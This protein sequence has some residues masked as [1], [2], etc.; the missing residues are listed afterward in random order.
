MYYNTVFG[1]MASLTIGGETRQDSG[2]NQQYYTK[3]RKK[4]TNAYDYSLTLANWGMFLQGQIKPHEKVKIVGGVRWDYFVQQFDN[5]LRPQNSGRGTP[6]IRS[7]KIGFVMTPTENVNIFGNVGCGFRSPAGTEVSPYSSS[8][9]PNFGLDPAM[10]QTYDIGCNATVFGN[11]YLAAEYY[12]TYTEREIKT[13]NGQAVNIGNTVRKGYELEARYYPSENLDFFV[14][15]AWVDAK[16]VDPT[17]AG[18]YYVTYIP[19]HLIKAGF[20]WQRDFGPVGKVVADLY[21][22]Y[23]SDAPLYKNSSAKIPLYAPDYDVYNMK[24]SYE[25]RGWSC[26][27]S[28][29]CQPREYSASY[30]MISNSELRFDP[31][32]QWEFTSGLTYSF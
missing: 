31:Q 30:F 8:G 32:P 28:A 9:K 29:R 27:A 5:L 4:T 1:D 3:N 23:L 14:N 7:P 22:Q 24:L 16:V 13:V 18:Q 19:E 11:L 25:G 6:H 2:D 21:Y 20:T 17:Y 10:I 12:H 15:Y 26:F